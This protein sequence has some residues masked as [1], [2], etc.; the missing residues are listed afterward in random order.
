MKRNVKKVAV[1]CLSLFLAVTNLNII[2]P[3]ASEFTDD[4]L[5]YEDEYAEDFTAGSSEE[6]FVD[7]IVEEVPEI[8]EE[9]SEDIS[10]SA[11]Y[12]EEISGYFFYRRDSKGKITITE[13]AGKEEVVNVP[14]EIKGMPV[15]KIGAGAFSGNKTM[16]GVNMHEIEEI[17]SGAFSE[18]KKLEYVNGPKVKKLEGGNFRHCTALKRVEMS[19]VETIGSYTF[20]FCGIEKADFPEVSE[21]GTEA[22]YK[23]ENLKTVSLPKLK[24]VKPDTFSYCE[25]LQYADVRSALSIAENA[26][27]NCTEMQSITTTKCED[28]GSHSFANCMSLKSI[29]FPQVKNI[30][31][32][33]FENCKKLFSV[34][35]SSKLNSVRYGAFYD[36]DSL[37]QISLYENLTDIYN[38]AFGYIR[39]KYGYP[40]KAENFTIHC[41]EGSKANMYAV[42]NDCIVT[43]HKYTNKL[44]KKANLTEDGYY[45]SICETCGHVKKRDKIAA[46]DSFV[47]S[48]LKFEYNGKVQKPKVDVYDTEE[49][50]IDPKYYI[51]SYSEE[52]SKVGVY[53]VHIQFKDKYEGEHTETYKIIRPQQEISASHQNLTLGTSKYIG[54]KLIK[55]DGKLTYK[56]DNIKVATVSSA[57][58]IKPKAVG[59]TSIYITANKTA[60]YDAK[61][62]RITVTVLPRA[63][64]ITAVSSGTGKL[65]VT[66]TKSPDAHGYVLYRSTSSKGTYSKIKTLS[67][68][69]TLSYT[70]TGLASN[71]R[72]YYKVR[73]YRRVSDKTYYSDYSAA[74]SSTTKK[75]KVINNFAGQYNLDGS[76]YGIQLEIS[77]YSDKLPENAV[78]GE[79]CANISVAIRIGMGGVSYSEGVLI[80]K[81]GN[82]YDIIGSDLRGRRLTVKNNSVY[83]SGSGAMHGTYDLTERYYS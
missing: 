13:Y 40:T 5:V 16:V 30:G 3:M 66:W 70:N 67:G 76:D 63:P 18:C 39:D 51:V 68:S 31:E 24:E 60:N 20:T 61:I 55:G 21:V 71:K 56:S 22:F 2:A 19:K 74:R 54:A 72:Y 58:K 83:V 50:K 28:I 26:F 4:I 8:S 10:A 27:L 23:C 34:E 57:G 17:G 46:I 69:G 80:K 1:E 82:D 32:C 73:A 79:E 15:V 45:D 14:T 48:G 81:S 43:F 49:K 64:K 77:V 52:S 42:R 41:E 65:K 62:K 47:Y 75:V 44:G 59:R 33:A 25:R 12:E 29:S 78:V 53:T 6:A 35:L 7:D 36:C 38:L 37:S 9:A 11:E